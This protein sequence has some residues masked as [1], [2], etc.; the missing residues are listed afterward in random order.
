MSSQFD[1]VSWQSDT[2]TP[3]FGIPEEEQPSRFIQI[4]DRSRTSQAQ[5]KSALD[6]SSQSRSFLSGIAAY[7][8]CVLGCA[9]LN[10]RVIDYIMP[11]LAER[12]VCFSNLF[13]ISSMKNYRTFLSPVL[14]LP[15]L[16]NKHVF[17][18][19]PEQSFFK[20]GVLAPIC[21]EVEF[22]FVLQ[23]LILKKI[24]Q[25]ILEK[26]APDYAEMIDKWP[27]QILRAFTVAVL[28]AAAHSQA[29][30]CED[31]GG[32]PQFVGG[33]LYGLINEYY[34]GDITHTINLHMLNNM[35]VMLT[36]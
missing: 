11:S 21:E 27:V 19:G 33:L 20:T 23:H 34:D 14:S 13:S 10:N 15:S 3:V 12:G 18:G 31:W 22:R 6:A 26:V 7:G 25:R 1:V 28:F 36:E 2:I 29:L 16:I 30:S 4:N 17:G 5:E 24:P 8:A 32:I 9:A 35:I